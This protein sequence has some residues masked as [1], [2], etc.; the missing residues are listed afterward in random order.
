MRLTRYGILVAL[1]LMDASEKHASEK[2][3]QGSLN[4]KEPPYHVIP[5][6]SLECPL[7]QFFSAAALGTSFFPKCS[8]HCAH[9]FGRIDPVGDSAARLLILALTVLGL[10]SLQSI[11]GGCLRDVVDITSNRRRSSQILWN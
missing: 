4:W 11:A 9:S 6:L 1:L 5:V 7:F 2:A 8:D 10:G 3:R